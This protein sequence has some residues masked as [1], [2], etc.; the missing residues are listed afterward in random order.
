MVLNLLLEK[1][2]RMAFLFTYGPMECGASKENTASRQ[3]AYCVNSTYPGTAQLVA[4]RF[5]NVPQRHDGWITM[6]QFEAADISAINLAQVMK[7]RTRRDHSRESSR[8]QL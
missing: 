4:R 1:P 3:G 6:T 5:G 8:R 2:P 7:Q